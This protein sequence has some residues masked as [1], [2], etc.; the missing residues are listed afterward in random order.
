MRRSTLNLLLALLLWVLPAT[1][2]ACQQGS[3]TDG[4]QGSTSETAEAAKIPVTTTSEEARDLYLQG[5]TLAENL[6]AIDA[7]EP[8]QQ[9]VQKDPTFASAYL[10]LA[11]TSQDNEGFF[12]NLEKA[13]ANMGTASEGERLQIQAVQAG[14]DGRADEQLALLKELVQK[15][16]E[17]ERAHNALANQLFFARQEYD[18][19]IAEYQKA[20]EI[21]P[22]YSASWNSMGYAARAAGRF[23]EA[24]NAFRKYIEVL[25]GEPNPYDSYA[26][27]LMKMGRH[28]ESIAQYR[29]A[30]EVEPTFTAS[31]VGII[32]NQMFMGQGDAARQTAD[33]LFAKAAND[34]IRRQALLWKAASYLYEGNQA[35]AMQILEERRAISEKTNDW[36]AVSGDDVLIGQTLLD[37][38]DAQKAAERFQWSIDE[39]EKADVPE[40]TKE[41]TRRNHLFNEARVALAKGDIALAKEKSAAYHTAVQTPAISF[42][43]RQ[44]HELM[45]RI[46]LAEGDASGALAHLGQA[47]Q[48]DPR[49]LLLTAQAYKASGNAEAATDMARQAA[50][51]NQLS[52]PL[53]YVRAEAKEMV[54]A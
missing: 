4:E 44:D 27:F 10:L 40:G 38:G 14:V 2:L 21:N 24:E 35:K 28:D 34:G 6:R 7:Q 12:S 33:A 53:S 50:D 49:V 3:Q 26:E 13:V 15:F 18:A 32:H 23:D 45:G 17:D 19:A 8:L 54:G 20:V 37:L 46:A 1:M 41:A 5:R 39:V 11:N 42:E 9:A 47:N 29:K 16:P 25:P 30:L 48:Q 43:L 22:E 31:D 51:F 52:F 36:L